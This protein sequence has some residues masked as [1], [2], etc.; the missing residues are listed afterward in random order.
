MALCVRA[1][2]SAGDEMTD[3]AGASAGPR[4]ARALPAQAEGGGP[5]A[6]APP[7][8]AHCPL[9]LALARPSGDPVKHL[10]ANDASRL[11]PS[12]GRSQ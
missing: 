11:I 8:Q 7:A 2:R 9:L 3:T 1:G 10:H 4:G 12:R 6:R 5:A